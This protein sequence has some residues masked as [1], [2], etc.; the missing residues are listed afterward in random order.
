[1]GAGRGQAAG[2]ARVDQATSAAGRIGGGG[3][4]GPGDWAGPGGGGA[5]PGGVPAEAGPGSRWA[6]RR[7]ASA[8]EGPEPRRHG[9][10]ARCGGRSD[11]C[12]RRSRVSGGH[13]GLRCWSTVTAGR[14]PARP[15]PV[16]AG[17]PRVPAGASLAPG[18]GRD[19]QPG[20]GPCAPRP[21]APGRAAATGRA[22]S[23]AAGRRAW[24]A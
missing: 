14:A 20:T 3:G 2:G 7:S 22:R 13:G 9:G 21:P 10:P 11:G 19:G 17:P 23:V 1:M 18:P 5:G 12:D 24:R 8:E 4:G 16:R 15:R 6:R